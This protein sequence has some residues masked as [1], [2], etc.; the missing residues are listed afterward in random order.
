MLKKYGTERAAV[1]NFIR[2]QQRKLREQF[3]KKNS[4]RTAKSALANYNYYFKLL[5]AQV[6]VD[7]VFLVHVIVSICK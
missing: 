1:D 7:H 6:L 3:K 5:L 4:G 2:G